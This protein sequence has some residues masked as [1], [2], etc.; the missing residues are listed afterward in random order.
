[1]QGLK[2]RTIEKAPTGSRAS[3]AM[4]LTYRRDLFVSSL[5]PRNG[6]PGK[7]TNK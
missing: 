2:C 5:H 4:L 7:V 1:M 3:Q 6:T